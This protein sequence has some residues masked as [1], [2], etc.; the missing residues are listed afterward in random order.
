[1]V[2]MHWGTFDLNR[3]PANEPPARV[4]AEALR[5][6]LEERIAILSPGQSLHW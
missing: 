1:M 3:E 4:L 2:P 6:G 5:R